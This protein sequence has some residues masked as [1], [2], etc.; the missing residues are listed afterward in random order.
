M[1]DRVGS[2]DIGATRVFDP[3]LNGRKLTFQPDPK[4]IRNVQT[5][6]RWNILGLTVEGPLKGKRLKPALHGNHFAFSWF[7]FKPKSAV[8]LP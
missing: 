2:R 4:G 1:N 8:Y 3:N 5:G 7:A 6:S